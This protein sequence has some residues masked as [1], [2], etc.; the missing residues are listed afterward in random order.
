MARSTTG[1]NTFIDPESL[2]S[3]PT[4]QYLHPSQVQE[5][6]RRK[7]ASGMP[8]VSLDSDQSLAPPRP[9]I[10]QTKSVFGVDKVWERELAKL[11]AAEEAERLEQAKLDALEARMEDKRKTAA[12]S[13]LVTSPD[14][15]FGVAESSSNRP[16]MGSR[17]ES[18]ASL[19]ARGW[20]NSP[21]SDADEGEELERRASVGSQLKAP[22]FS[23][24]VS[25]APRLPQIP[26]GELDSDEEDVPLAQQ[27]SKR[28]AASRQ[29]SR[30]TV[31]AESDSDEDRPIAALKRSQTKSSVGGFNIQPASPKEDKQA[32]SSEDELPLGVRHPSF[33]RMS[34]VPSVAT[35]KPPADA[36]SDE[37]DKPLGAKFNSSANIANNAALLQ[38]QQM[39]LQQQMMQQ[40]MMMRASMAFGGS[41]M[42]MN[43]AMMGAGFASP[44][45]APAMSMNSLNLGTLQS[46]QDAQ[47]SRVES[48]R[49]DV[50]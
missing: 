3:R 41:M 30:P 46:A 15:E 9:G 1:P 20:F 34:S 22:G 12:A 24:K 2:N 4:T 26:S 19:G 40:Q 50:V 8:L 10:P 25:D 16:A 49:R 17:R 21:A 6:I 11:R 7:R 38:Q 44:F 47:H 35:M 29:N 13:A 32:E 27:L 37:D 31:A 43:P 18:A 23:R 28:G 36:E 14:A 42:N 5:E 48:W 33:N 39:L 45:A